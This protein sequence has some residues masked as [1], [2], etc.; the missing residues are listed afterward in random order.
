MPQ[1]FESQSYLVLRSHLRTVF[2]MLLDPDYISFLQSLTAD[3]T[4][5]EK[6]MKLPG[7]EQRE[8]LLSILLRCHT[9]TKWRNRTNHV[10]L[11]C[12]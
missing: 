7:T 11:Q 1:S 12:T 10:I 9:T 6:E 2:C 5:A 8:L 3:P 4:D